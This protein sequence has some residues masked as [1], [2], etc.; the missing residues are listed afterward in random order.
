MVR[1]TAMQR[2][3][4]HVKPGSRGGAFARPVEARLSPEPSPVR[5]KSR[6]AHLS[7]RAHKTGHATIHASRHA[8]IHASLREPVLPSGTARR[9]RKRPG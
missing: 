5:R 9:G 3:M 6:S 8:T 7:N 1:V 4:F 2:V